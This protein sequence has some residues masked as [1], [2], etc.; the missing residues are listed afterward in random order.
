MSLR[1]DLALHHAEY[2]ETYL[3]AALS[4]AERLERQARRSLTWY[5]DD[6]EPDNMDAVSLAVLAYLGAAYATQNKEAFLQACAWKLSFGFS[7]A[8]QHRCGAGRLSPEIA[9]AT[10]L[11]KHDAARQIASQILR[12]DLGDTTSDVPVDHTAM[13]L[14]ALVDVDFDRAACVASEVEA[15][16]EGKRYSRDQ[17]AYHKAFAV[18]AGKLARLNAPA[19]RAAMSELDAER[20]R[21]LSKQLD[22][23][24]NGSPS[25]LHQMFMFDYEATALLALAVNL[26]GQE[27]AAGTMPR[28]FFDLGWIRGS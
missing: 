13:I 20:H 9:I 16:C 27:A 8:P 12:Q 17:S 6:G 23:A 19:F 5:I 18:A 1:T 26:M 28:R 24:A 10:M 25:D 2:L 11:G 7:N 3:K 14:A 15:A 21:W 4:D 22:R